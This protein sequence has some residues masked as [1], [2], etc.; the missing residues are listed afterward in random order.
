MPTRTTE[1]SENDTN[2]N[3]ERDDSPSG[4]ASLGLDPLI[5]QALTT[6]GY[7]EPTPIQTETIPALIA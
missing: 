4:F 6:L 3:S 7:E 1:T 2:L 5:L